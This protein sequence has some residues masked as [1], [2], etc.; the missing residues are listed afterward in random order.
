[1]E[2]FGVR[3]VRDLKE[4]GRKLPVTDELKEEYIALVCQMKMTGDF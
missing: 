3:D 4:D 1:M 2:E